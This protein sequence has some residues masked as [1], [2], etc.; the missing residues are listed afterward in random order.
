[1]ILMGC[2]MLMRWM[3]DDDGH[4]VVRDDDEDEGVAKF[5]LWLFY[6]AKPYPSLCAFF[7]YEEEKKT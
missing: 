7:I 2:A 6:T 4:V 1:M 3:S 5:S